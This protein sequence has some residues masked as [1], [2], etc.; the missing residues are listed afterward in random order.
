[1]VEDRVVAA[2]FT[3]MSVCTSSLPIGVVE[4]KLDRPFLFAI[5]DVNGLPLFVGTVYQPE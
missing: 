2:A 3:E 4:M 1:M 5:Y